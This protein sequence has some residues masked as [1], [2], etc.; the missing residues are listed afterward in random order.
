MLPVPRDVDELTFDAYLNYSLFQHSEKFHKTYKVKFGK[1]NLEKAKRKR[2]K[3]GQQID[4]SY[5]DIPQ[6]GKVFAYR[7][8]QEKL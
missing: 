4:S 8:W 1:E 3:S 7:L 2:E 6:K 5:L